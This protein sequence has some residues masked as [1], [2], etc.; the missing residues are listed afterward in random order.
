MPRRWY[1]T[2]EIDNVVFEDVNRKDSIYWNE[3]KWNNFIAPLLP[4]ECQ[5][6]LE[7][8]TNAGLFLKMATDIGFT[9]VT[10][11][12]GNSRIMAQAREYKASID[13]KYKLV[14]ELVG[15]NLNLR[16][17][18]LAD[19]VLIANTHYYFPVGVFSRLV[20]E[21]RNRC[22]YCI[23]VS[24]KAKRRQGNATYDLE[25][26][27]GYFRDWEEARLID[28]VVDPG[29]AD[30]CP[31]ER[32]FGVLFKSNLNTLFVDDYYDDWYEAAKVPGHKSHEL[33]SALQEFTHEI[34]KNGRYIEVK[35]TELYKYWAL[36][37][38]GKSL[39]WVANAMYDK[40]DLI[41]N[42]QEN[43]IK[44]PIY[45]NKRLKL[46]DGLHR[47]STAKALCYDHILARV[48]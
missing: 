27:R 37:T 4:K 8:G 41:L 12:E 26:V 5:T 14:H 39:D 29:L 3:G 15:H 9:N 40:R 23:V 17:F 47:L 10:G 25:S 24:A 35:D 19:V 46:L 22:L 34:L 28:N 1:Q 7:I 48:L 43:G 13:G 11:V 45:L 18:P 42:I 16:N 30:P 2:L 36:R 38:P 44:E 6:F 32:M 20:D 21:L 31:R 33:A